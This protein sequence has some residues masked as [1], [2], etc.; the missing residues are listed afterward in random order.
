V[1]KLEPKQSLRS[2]RSRRITLLALA[3][4]FLLT[5]VGLGVFTVSTAHFI[6][7]EPDG[8]LP[9]TRPAL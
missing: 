5:L 9:F 2:Q 6:G 8:R 1:L 7:V 3:F 4:A